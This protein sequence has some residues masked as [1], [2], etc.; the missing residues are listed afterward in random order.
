LVRHCPIASKFSRLSPSGSILAWQ[1]AHTGF[2][3]CT[4]NICRT[5]SGFPSLLLNSSA[6]TFGGGAGGG[7]ARIFSSSHLPRIVGD[8]RVV[9]DVTASTLALPSS[10]KR[11]SS[12]STTRRK[13]L[14]YTPEIP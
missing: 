2:A 1:L 5:V 8:V 4:S 13:W 9:Y 10:P 14:P 3:R 7:A 12:V 6:G 11:F